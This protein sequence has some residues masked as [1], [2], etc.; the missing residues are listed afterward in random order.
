METYRDLSRR[1]QDARAAVMQEI[2]AERDAEKE[3]AVD[4]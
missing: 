2:V 3:E 1:I 4:A